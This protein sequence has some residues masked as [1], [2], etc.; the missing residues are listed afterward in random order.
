MKLHDPEAIEVLPRP[1]PCSVKE[2]TQE[3]GS[4]TGLVSRLKKTITRANSEASYKI[5]QIDIKEEAVNSI[6]NESVKSTYKVTPNSAGIWP[7]LD[8]C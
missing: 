4:T 8:T 7:H 3:E 2:R 1:V 6:I 5:L